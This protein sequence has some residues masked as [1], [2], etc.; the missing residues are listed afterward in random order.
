MALSSHLGLLWQVA[1]LEDGRE[2]GRKRWKE[3]RESH[4][5]LLV[6]VTSPVMGM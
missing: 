5:A 2:G 1:L 3:K 6:E 4:R